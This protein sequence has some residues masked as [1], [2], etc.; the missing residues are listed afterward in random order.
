MNLKDW[1][2]FENSGKVAD[3]LKFLESE[4]QGLASS[5]EQTQDEAF[6]KSQSGA[7]PDAGIYYSYGDHIEAVSRGG[8]RQTYQPFD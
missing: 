2:Q 7:D 5:K 4:N 6:I 3:Y 1:K 8:I